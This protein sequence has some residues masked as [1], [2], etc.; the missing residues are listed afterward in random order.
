MVAMG[1]GETPGLLAF[2]DHNLGSLGCANG[3]ALRRA[4][5][6]PRHLR[7]HPPLVHGC[8]PR[9]GASPSR[10]VLLVLG[11]QHNGSSS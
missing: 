3:T 4:M 7:C 10:S 2:D 6:D 9:Q 11:H 5:E 8:R 1:C